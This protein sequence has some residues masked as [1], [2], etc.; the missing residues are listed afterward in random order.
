MYGHDTNI[1]CLQ[2]I[3]EIIKAVLGE[4]EIKSEEKRDFA[5]LARYRSLSLT[6]QLRRSLSCEWKASRMIVVS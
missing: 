4:H 2:V 1:V 5:V 6:M 3:P